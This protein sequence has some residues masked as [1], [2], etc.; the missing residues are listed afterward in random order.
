MNGSYRHT[1]ASKILHEILHYRRRFSGSDQDISL[2]N[3]LVLLT[4][5]PRIQTF[6]SAN[7]PIHFILPAF[8]AKSPNPNKVLGTVPDMAEKLA[9]TFLNALCENIKAHY[10]PGARLTI[11][12]DGHVFSDL[13]N[14]NDDTI[15]TY[16]GKIK[17]LIHDEQL[18]CLDVLNLG[19]IDEFAALTD[20][21]DVLRSTLLQGYADPLED[22]RTFL[23]NDE[24]GTR[25]YRAI[26]RFMFEDGLMPDYQGSKT[27]LQRDA[28]QRAYGVI[29]S[30]WAWGNLLAQCFPDAIRLSIHP[31]PASSLKMGIHMLPTKD[32]WLTPWHGTAVEVDG[33]FLL[34]KKTEAVELNAEPV[35]V[36]GKH[37]HYTLDS[38]KSVAHA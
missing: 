13:I 36:D 6:V 18:N 25:L 26:T 24:D 8:P 35:W 12:S 23:I 31:Q 3:E 4:Q 5:L 15:N 37:S 33:T 27:A 17:A 28:R 21:Y 38:R 10:A 19:D 9:L 29:Q 22:I 34:M 16:Q 32:D 14:V 11:C 1:T 7:L 2:E 20:D 30:S